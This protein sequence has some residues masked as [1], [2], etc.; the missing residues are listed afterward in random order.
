MLAFEATAEINA[1]PDV[2]W[3]HLS[4]AQDFANWDPDVTQF[5][6]EIGLNQKFTIHTK[7]NP[8]R[9]FSVTCTEFVPNEKMVWSSGMP[10]GLFKGRR[11]F[12]LSATDSGQTHYHVR[13]EFSGLLLPLFRGSIPDLS[14]AFQRHADALKAV[15]EGA[16]TQ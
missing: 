16:P 6:G 2:V 10:L 4:S 11:T 12:T 1:T 13:E 3:A 5:E 8:D 9:A 15:S 7:V 14:E